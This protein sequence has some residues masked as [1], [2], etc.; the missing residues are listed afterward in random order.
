M[1]LRKTTQNED[2]HDVESTIYCLKKSHKGIIIGKD[3]RTLKRIGTYARL[4][5]EKIL[6][7]KVNLKLWVKIQEDWQGND[8]ILKRFKNE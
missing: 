4:D 5:I 6:N 8:N 3:G 1:E 2:I 7:T